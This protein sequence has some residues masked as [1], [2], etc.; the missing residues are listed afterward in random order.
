MA[1]STLATN[2]NI[3]IK[4]DGSE[5][6]ENI[7][8]LADNVGELEIFSNYDK[9]DYARI[10]FQNLDGEKGDGSSSG[11]LSEVA[12]PEKKLE[13]F[14][15][16]G[17]EEFNAD[18][19]RVFHGN[20]VINN[21]AFVAPHIVEI[22]GMNKLHKM[23][24]ETQTKAFQGNP[25]KWPI[26]LI[27]HK[28]V[29]KQLAGDKIAFGENDPNLGHKHVH[30]LGRSKY[31]LLCDLAK[32]VGRRFW[33]SIDDNDTLHYE[34][35]NKGKTPVCKLILNPKEAPNPSKQ[36]P[37]FAMERFEVRASAIGVKH[38]AQVIAWNPDKQEQ[39]RKETKEVKSELVKSNATEK[40]KDKPTYTVSW[41]GD[42]DH[43]QSLADSILQSLNMN[44]TLG[45]CHI[46]GNPRMRLGATV[47]LDVKDTRFNGKYY[48]FSVHHKYSVSTGGSQNNGKGTF[49]TEIQVQ[50]DGDM[51]S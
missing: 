15:W 35:Y 42:P 33:I 41:P 22:H 36:V 31:E 2:A 12:Q 45:T 10:R 46:A 28:D 34:A 51:A 48:I 43:A 38:H 1:E 24:N 26:E 44:Y 5:K 13:I 49:E 17:G 32:L 4:I 20:I 8:K 19:H 21:P 6:F 3:V 16:S 27:A 7:T 11:R 29:I 18:K 47:D 9:P 37:E 30:P 39:V 14:L 25:N 40:N 23:R 50:R